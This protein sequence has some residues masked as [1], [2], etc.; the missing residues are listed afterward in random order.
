MMTLAEEL[1]SILDE[2]YEP[3]ADAAYAVLS[4]GGDPAALLGAE[5]EQARQFRITDE[6]MA[7]WAIRKIAKARKEFDEAG[8]VADAQIARISDWLARKKRDMERTEEFFGGLLRAYYQPQH[9]ADPKR[10]KTFRLPSGQVQFRAQQPE[11]KRDDEALLG[12]LKANGREDY[13]VSKESPA[14]GELKKIL[15][16][17]GEHMI[18]TESGEIVEGIFVIERPT[19]I[20][21]VTAT[22]TEQGEV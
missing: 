16:Q 20:K 17:H 7:D 14:W 3:I 11:Y 13:I 12:W 1:D 2:A 19:V 10:R 4:A 9:E 8:K 18:D 21:I 15:K 22:E 5:D 6:G